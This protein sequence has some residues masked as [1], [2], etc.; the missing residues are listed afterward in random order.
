VVWIIIS[1]YTDF[2]NAVLYLMGLPC[3]ISAFLLMKQS[4]IKGFLMACFLSILSFAV[5]EITISRLETVNMFYHK[6]VGDEI[7][8]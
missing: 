2:N 3:G 7:R 8:M 4:R 6:V 1:F 5:T